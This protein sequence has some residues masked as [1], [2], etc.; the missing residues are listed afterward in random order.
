MKIDKKF[1]IGLFI[2]L[3]MIMFVMGLVGDFTG[4]DDSA[5]Q[6]IIELREGYEPWF[7][8]VWTP[9]TDFAEKAIFVLQAS[10]AAG[11]IILSMVKMKKKAVN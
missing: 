7:E 3:M 9:P 5:N 4:S 6:A 8:S 11:F 2:A 10:V 1:I